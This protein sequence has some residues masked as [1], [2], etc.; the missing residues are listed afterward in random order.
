M[1][2]WKP[3]IGYEDSYMVSNQGRVKS[4]EKFIKS[5][6]ETRVQYRPEKILKQSKNIWGYMKVWLYKDSKRKEVFVHRLVVQA[7]LENPDNKPC[8]N[9]IDNDKTNNRLE[10]LEWCTY[11]ENSDWSKIQGRRKITGTWRENIIKTRKRKPVIGT[12][13]EGKE[14]YFKMVRAVEEMGFN[15][16]AVIDCCKGKMKSTKGF[17]W[18]Y[19]E[20]DKEG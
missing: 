11:Q 19:A 17:T 14:Y 2:I 15:T 3:V 20:A 4:L 13:S 12:D 5:H 6:N 1:E 7:F 10:N 8:V 18:R 16:K 9:H